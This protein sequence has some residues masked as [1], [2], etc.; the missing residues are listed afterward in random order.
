M[1]ITARLPIPTRRRPIL[2]FLL[3][4]LLLA[5]VV[6]G[7]AWG[8]TQANAKGP[9][10]PD[11]DLRE[12]I[13][14]P[15]AQQS[16]QS[17]ALVDR[18][19]STMEAFVAARQATQ[20]G[21]RL[22]PNRYGIPKLMLRDGKT[23]SAASTRDPDQIAKT[24]LLAN[25]AVFPFARS[26]VDQLRLVVRDVTPEATYLVFNQTLNGIDVFQG[27][28]KFT[29][30]KTGEVIQV[31]SGEVV[32]GLNTSTIPG[33]RPEDA[34]LAARTAARAGTGGK[35]L[36]A[37][38]LVIF[39]LDASAA[40][41]AYHLFLELD[42][43]R[44]YEILIDAQDGKLLF[45][46]N[47]YVHAAQGRVWTQSPSQGSRQLVTF[48]DGW[49]PP[50]GTV[51][52]G[53]N[54]DAFIDAN[55][56]DQPDPGNT[57]ELQT[58][59]A[60]SATQLFDFSFGDGTLGQDPRGFKAASVTNLFYFVN[61]AHDFYYD[62]GFTEAAG[63]F[64]TDNFNQ[65]GAAGDAII[66]EGQNGL[67]DDDSTFAPTPDGIP[68]RMRLGIYTRGTPSQT[69]DTDFDYDGQTVI[70]E[71]GHGVS[72]RLV[73]GGT[74]TSCLDRIQSGALGE[75][76]S[77][78]FAISYF[79]NPVLGAYLNQDMIHGIRRQ[80]YE[81]YTFTY[82][83]VGNSGYEVH[84]DGEI[85][86]AA[87]WDL[88]KALG[89]T[90]TD[91]L[92]I[93]GLK[94]TPCNPSM[95]DAR[96]A[97]LSADLASNSGANRVSIWT[98]FAKHGLGYSA[99]GID[100]GL[101]TGT[102]YDAAYDLPPDLQTNKNP[103]ITSQ[104]LSVT[105][106]AGGLYAYTVTASNPN[107]GV[108]S[109]ALTSGPAGLTVDPS[110]AVTW[111][112]SFTAQR[113]K[114]TVTDGKGGKV[115]H[116]YLAPVLTHLAAGHPVVISGAADSAGYA[117]IDVPSGLPILQVTLRG[118]N[119]DADLFV[120]DPDGNFEFSVRDGNNETLSFPSPK[121]GRWQVEA[122]AYSTYSGV[123]LTASLV[124]PAPLSANKIVGG[125]SGVLGSETFYRVTIPPGSASFQISTAGVA[126]DMDLYLK[127]GSP[128]TCQSSLMVS[129][130][131]NDDYRSENVGNSE[132]ITVTNPSSGDWYLDL[133]AYREFSGVSL[134]T[135]LSAA[136]PKP[137]LSI[138]KSHTGNFTPGQTGA[139]YTITV[140]NPGTAATSGPVSVADTLPSG[141]T[142]TAIG[143]TGWTCLLASLNC[144]RSDALAPSGSYPP[145]TVTV[146]VAAN[147]AGSLTNTA[148]VSGGGESNTSNDTAHDVTVIGG[149]TAGPVI[150]LVANA[151][152]DNP[153]IAPNTWIE[154]KGS[155]LAPAADT[156]IWVDADFVN[157]TMPVQ[158]D[159]VSVTVNG[160]SA[161]VY[162]ISPTQINV[163]TP[164][165]ALSGSI[166]VQVTNNGAM[167][168]MATVPGQE[169][170]LSFFEFVSAG[171]LHYVYGRHL[172]GTLIGPPSL[173]PG[174]SIPV[175]PGEPIYVAA[176][177]FGPTDVPVVS[178]AVT[179]SGNLPLPF[180]ELKIGG[181][182]APVSFAGLVGVGTYVINFTVP[183]D[184]P[185]GDLPLTATY[186]G[187]SI[188]PNLLI[189]V[190]H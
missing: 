25:A 106:G 177:G 182:P 181:I 186:N 175:K 137:D 115:V 116:G 153:L 171:G 125:L 78:Y 173:F 94:A 68:P 109:F 60:V 8:Q 11:F 51:T 159:G 132:F 17:K 117:L 89:Q 19:T 56:D 23:L 168:N 91:R 108:L 57:G 160:K 103:A 2:R 50:A 20:S 143:G 169:Q 174:S 46:H 102:L 87:L 82:E 72:N 101:D 99:R 62:L 92:V 93:G 167:S 162:Y 15:G 128:V 126:G 154:I 88:R 13:V 12:Q 105:V 55:G 179:Q 59:R 22:V 140:T 30:S 112:A 40:R 81:G 119:G 70:H 135:W 84:D 3:P 146:D 63:N 9:V 124:T 16:P 136:P 188:Q 90:T 43:Q 149:V 31:G 190:Q 58:G 7:P 83:D 155:N 39:A 98:V 121:A 118:G 157:N 65:G 172:D 189:T 142:A 1:N 107:A 180:P 96:D 158:L 164:P 18:R 53:N 47:A 100:G 151:F 73:G 148:T 150:T 80:S 10:L 67:S 187:L 123:A 97:I 184:A 110:G 38:E 114:I 26:E 74:D 183:S 129:T 166:N 113:I 138:S 134:T 36:R 185:D 145:I 27:Q 71:Y 130:G 131:C 104:P 75:G 178:G 33:I 156:R 127:Y 6:I 79:N 29:L 69:D 141:L 66:A 4:A 95:T 24:F 34:E 86:A 21:I 54:V 152:A 165:D 161:Y 61:L 48:P 35:F 139:V 64:Q 5:A 120:T 45:R 14:S 170:S 176:N 42:A 147:A 32:P 28:I 133:S 52:T 37:P 85:W 111:I 44:L 76:W 122:D 163:V 144:T 77:D 49:L 41:L